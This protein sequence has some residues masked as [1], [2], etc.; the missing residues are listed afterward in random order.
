M[1]LSPVTPTMLASSSV[2][3]MAIMRLATPHSATAAKPSKERHPVP[4]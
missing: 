1:G 3:P 4:R 2:Y